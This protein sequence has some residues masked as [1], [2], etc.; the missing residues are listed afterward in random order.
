MNCKRLQVQKF[1]VQRFWGLKF[2]VPSRV[3]DPLDRATEF[4]DRCILIKYETPQVFRPSRIYYGRCRLAQATI[5]KRHL[6]CIWGTFTIAQL[7]L[8]GHGKTLKLCVLT[9]IPCRRHKTNVVKNYMISIYYRNSETLI[10]RSLI[11]QFGGIGDGNL[12]FR[13]RGN[14]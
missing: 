11:P 4:N 12:F 8:D 14:F 10:I 2:V 5:A 3:A 13:A 9:N 1:K 7:K 6:P